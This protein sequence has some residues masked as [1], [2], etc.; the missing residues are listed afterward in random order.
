MPV[1]D[2]GEEGP[3]PFRVYRELEEAVRRMVEEY[4]ELRG[5]VREL[6]AAHRE[7]TEA[8]SGAQLDALEPGRIEER[9]RE[10]ARENRELREIVEEG[11]E[12][13]RR[14]RSRLVMMEDEV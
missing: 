4:G 7:L 1:S 10:L 6:E 9:L 5:R 13:A 12:R 8:V 2:P 11:R 3:D 14:I